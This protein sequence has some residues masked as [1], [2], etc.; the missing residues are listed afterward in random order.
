[1]GLG[2][3]RKQLVMVCVLLAGTF[4]AVL[5]ATLL[6]PAL[7]SIMS[8]L[9][10]TST[11]AQW[12]TSGYALIEAVVIPLSAYL[13][14]RFPT[15]RLFLGGL[16]IF[17]AGSLVALVAPSFPVLMVGRA[18]Q[19]AATGAVLPMVSSVIL[20]VFPRERRGSA[21]GVIGLI[22][23]FAPTIGPTL[24]GVLVDHLGWRSIFGVVTIIA[25]VIIAVASR[26]LEDF[27]QFERTRFDAPSVALSSVGLVCLLYGL[28]TF[29]SSANHVVTVV[30]VVMGVILVALYARR[31]LRLDEPMLRVGI[32]ATAR[33]RTAVVIIALFQAALI[34]METVMPLY[35]QGVLGESATMSG[36]TLLP[37]AVIGAVVGF[38]AGRLFDRHG[39]RRPVLVGATVIFVAAVGFVLLRVNSPLAVV[40]VTYAVMAVG[41]QFTMTPLNTWGVNSLPNDA[42][43]HAQSTSNTINQVA[44]SFGTALL[45]SIANTVSGAATGLSGVEQTFAGYHASFSTTALLTCLAVVLI[46]VFVR[47]RK[48][49]AATPQPMGARGGD[50]SAGCATGAAGAAGV[51]GTSGGAVVCVR[52]AMNPA[53]PSVPASATMFDVMDAMEA[54]D[55]SGVAVVDERGALV[56]YVT[57][58]DVARYLGRNDKSYASPSANIY[59][60][61]RDNDDVRDRLAT[62]ASLNVMALATTHVI[63]VEA[64]LP[65]DKACAVLAE[66]DIKKMPVTSDGVLVGALSRRNVTH[67]MMGQMRG[68]RESRG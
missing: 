6:A 8:H 46:C 67:Y 32:L 20:L 14:G 13:M 12:L 66:R 38:F 55:T 64:D 34:G 40:S 37:G 47:D 9:G 7:P 33:Y 56:G 3:T 17:G 5:N 39:V 41:I 57:D 28:S 51:A 31:Q 36:L 63:T 4:L 2:I 49:A 15:R 11:T 61:F 27:G 43:R 19:A 21:M 62:L 53:A 42:I 29:S 54:T 24:S 16:S 26:A 18:L 58:G 1:M 50:Q 10:V 22:I 59:A 44:G 68:D 30:L 60:L 35:I 25:L 23:G 48:G 45:V 65:L 52:D